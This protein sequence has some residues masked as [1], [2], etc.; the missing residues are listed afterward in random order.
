MLCDREE[1]I[2]PSPK[3]LTTNCFLTVLEMH[4]PVVQDSP[5]NAKFCF[6]NVIQKEKHKTHVIHTCRKVHREAFVRAMVRGSRKADQHIQE[7]VKPYWKLE[8]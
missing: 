7:S 5:Q 2:S 6:K 4:F 8:E 1:H 3:Y